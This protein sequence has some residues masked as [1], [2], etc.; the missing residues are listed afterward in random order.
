MKKNCLEDVLNFRN[1]ELTSRA[2]LISGDFSLP[3]VA[4]NVLARTF[5]LRCCNF[6]EFSSLLYFLVLA[7]F[8]ILAGLAVVFG[9][10]SLVSSSF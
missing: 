5:E 6:P 3:I 10:L 2:R 7:V 1:S 4:E 8:E 9:V